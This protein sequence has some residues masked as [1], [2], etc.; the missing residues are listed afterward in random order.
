M[1]ISQ[2]YVGNDYL[3][4]EPKWC[5]TMLLCFLIYHL[6]FKRGS[7]D[8]RSNFNRIYVVSSPVSGAANQV[9]AYP[10]DVRRIQVRCEKVQLVNLHAQVARLYFCIVPHVKRNDASDQ[11]REAFSVMNIT[12]SSYIYYLFTYLWILLSLNNYINHIISYLLRKRTG[13]CTYILIITSCLAIDF[14]ARTSGW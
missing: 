6:Q 10:C 14:K 13:C 3:L 11:W 5:Q 2:K 12:T 1:F 7:W 9:M 8:N 4:V